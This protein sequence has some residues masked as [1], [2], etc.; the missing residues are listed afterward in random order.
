MVKFVWQEEA[1]CHRLS[2][3]TKCTCPPSALHPS[4]RFMENA[5]G[6]ITRYYVYIPDIEDIH[7]I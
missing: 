2:I 5:T 1:A 4:E 3:R 7:Q 6:D